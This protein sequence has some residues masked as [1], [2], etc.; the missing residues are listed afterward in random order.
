MNFKSKKFWIS[1]FISIIFFVIVYNVYEGI[2][3]P[4]KTDDLE[5]KEFTIIKGQ[6]IKEIAHNLKKEGL[7]RNEIYFLLYAMFKNKHKVIQAGQHQ[8]NSAMNVP[9][10]L[11]EITQPKNTSVKFRINAG[12]T[13]ENISKELQRQNIFSQNQILKFKEKIPSDFL[14]QFVFLQ[15]EKVNGL[16]GYLY[17]DTYF[18]NKNEGT[19]KFIEKVLLNFQEKISPLMSEIKKQ[20]KSLSDII[21]MASI[22][23][24]EA[25]RQEDKEIIS[26]I[27]WKRLKYNIP[28]QSDTT[29]HYLKKDFTS[30]ISF[31]DLK[32]DSKYNTYRYTGLP[33]GPISNPSIESILAALYPKDTPY[34]FFLADQNGKIYF[35]Q[36]FAEHAIKKE[37]LL[38]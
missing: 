4:A 2:Y 26:G 5:N 21:I 28:L 15:D 6:G 17:P 27:F 25:S 38:K 11:S 23:E 20:G 22:I 13:L 12:W 19:E 14:T 30:E 24:K 16:E 10:I 7:L 9:E 18:I 36:T 3:L 33:K 35:S 31:L 1:I 34:W 29:I 8:L 37:K 32:I